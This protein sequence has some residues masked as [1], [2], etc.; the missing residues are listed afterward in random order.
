MKRVLVVGISGAGKS[1]F[2]NQ[3]GKRLGL[4]VIHLDKYFWKSGW[5]ETPREQ[6]NETV[7]QLT[8]KDEWVIDGNFLA[9]INIRFSA[10]DT[11]IHLD[12]NRWLALYRVCKRILTGYGKTRFDLT[13][14]C[15]ER[16]NLPFLKY[17][18]SF[19]RKYRPRLESKIAQFCG[20][21]RIYRFRRQHEVDEFLL[22]LEK[23]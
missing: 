4:E 11:I 23:I 20:V 6:W 16:F 12:I 13:E 18:L 9:S 17:I 1:T 2:A 21:K 8:E 22:S 7:K 19:P 5:R 10:A 14:G 3:L 15:P